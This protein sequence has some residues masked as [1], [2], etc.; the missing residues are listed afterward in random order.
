MKSQNIKVGHIYYV[1]F[2]PVK[3]GE[4]GK[5]HLAIAIKKNHDKI[6]YVVIPMT[7]KSS[8]LG[9]NKIA[10]GKLTCLPSN[11]QTNESYAVID[12]LRTVN[13]DRFYELK[14]NGNVV[15]AELPRK[16]MIMLYKAI[17]QDLL[18]DVPDDEL[19]QIFS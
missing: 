5:K 7:S 12:Q 18:H 15:D 19:K 8:G 3:K 11:L 17:I 1:D 16:Q 2:E 13:A 10:L 9:V 4:F 14:D 6:T